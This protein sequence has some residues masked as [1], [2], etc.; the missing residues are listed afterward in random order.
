MEAGAFAASRGDP[1]ERDVVVALCAGLRRGCRASRQSVTWIPHRASLRFDWS[2]RC[3]RI[4]SRP[5]RH[6]VHAKFVVGL[7]PAPAL[8]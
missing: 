2:F 3:A 4:L 6:P 1:S 7:A 5:R 8:L